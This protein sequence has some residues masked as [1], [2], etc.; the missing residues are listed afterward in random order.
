MRD[1]EGERTNQR[2]MHIV[3]PTIP[4][5]PPRT[6]PAVV[7]ALV[8]FGSVLLREF[9][10]FGWLTC[11]P[12]PHALVRIALLLVRLKLVRLKLDVAPRWSWC[13]LVTRQ[14]E[15]CCIA[16]PRCSSR[17]PNVPP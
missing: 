16:P 9:W 6:S 1:R 13:A 12:R 2:A 3:S 5:N 14:R 4:P 10:C 17:R 15:W 11:K 8:P 7:M